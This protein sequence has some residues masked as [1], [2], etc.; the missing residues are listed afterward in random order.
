[1]LPQTFVYN[2]YTSP[3]WYWYSFN[4]FISDI[5]GGI[6][7]PLSKFADDTKMS[8]MVDTAEGRDAIQRNLDKLKRWAL[9][10]LMRFNKQ[11]AKLCIGVGIIPDMHT[12]WE[13]NFLRVALMRRI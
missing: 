12:N 5:Y 9:V 13:K 4:I 10:N 8:S 3:S 7:H 11:S 2:L 6:E 1:M